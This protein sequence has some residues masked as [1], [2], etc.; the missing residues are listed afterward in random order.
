[1]PDRVVPY[2][3]GLFQ[4]LNITETIVTICECIPVPILAIIIM[5]LKVLK[6]VPCSC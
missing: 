2:D 1:M 4:L 3:V 5:L 6:E